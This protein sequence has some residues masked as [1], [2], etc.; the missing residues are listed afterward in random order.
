M[1]SKFQISL[2]IISG[3]ILI[4]EFLVSII[5]PEEKKKLK[6]IGGGLILII[7]LFAI[8]I[9]GI[10][11]SKTLLEENNKHKAER[12]ID[13]IN[14]IKIE[15]KFDSIKKVYDSI[16]LQNRIFEINQLSHTQ[17]I[18]SLYSELY[19]FTQIAR[20]K[21]PDLPIKVGLNY[22]YEE[23][24][25]QNIKIA[26]IKNDIEIVSIEA[27]REQFRTIVYYNWE[28]VLIKKRP[29]GNDVR[30]DETSSIFK[31]IEKLYNNNKHIELQALCEKT[32]NSKK[33]W[34]TPYIYLADI[35]FRN[36]DLKKADNLLNIV[37]NE[38]YDEI[39]VDN[40]KRMKK[41]I[42]NLK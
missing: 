27:K 37:L 1:L 18:D 31:E 20:K 16:Y 35:Y 3:I 13:S 2:L 30:I 36:G 29:N 23:L 25:K 14:Q 17:K 10:E 28:G 4:L 33:N 7:G 39:S 38:S 24:L 40:A 9:S 12:K 21:Y 6:I 5:I 8:V 22:I 41:R 26:E 42:N 32:I 15:V 19:P 11:S 34:Y